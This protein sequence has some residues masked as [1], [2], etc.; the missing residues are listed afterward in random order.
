M[1]GP[2]AGSNKN[3]Y[4]ALDGLR[5][6]AALS[7]MIHHFISYRGATIFNNAAVA[8]DLFFILSGFVI[9][10]SYCTRL[11]SGMG[12]SE[13]MCRR[14][15]RLYPMFI[16]GIVIGTPVLYFVTIAGHSDFSM[17]DILDTVIH[18]GLF[19][20]YFANKW[21]QSL[22]GHEPVFGE[23]FPANPPAWSLFFEIF[24]SFAFVALAKMGRKTLKRIIIISYAS[25]VSG[26][27]LLTYV[28]YG[29]E[30]DFGQGWGT[31]NFIL[32]FPRVL[33]GFTFGVF[34]YRFANEGNWIKARNICKKYLRS[35]WLLYLAFLAVSAL[36]TTLDGLYPALVL[37]TVVP[38]LVFVGAGIDCNNVFDTT[39]SK[40][41]GWISY[42]IYC[43]HYPVGR[44]V[45]LLAAGGRYSSAEAVVLSIVIT[46]IATVIVTKLYEEPARAYLTRKFLVRLKPP[47]VPV[48]VIAARS[49]PGSSAGTGQPNALATDPSGLL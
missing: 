28:E 4:L 37:A 1:F 13:Y 43:L 2:S 15:I 18:N 6:I 9:T 26:I 47:S 22:G 8:V 14:F 39:A 27:L 10:H 5:G 3:R 25:F 20:P 17:R 34:L 49:E 35:P 12:T 11:Q 33:F 44:G 42:P 45:F 30:L 7:V 46:V 21:I 38:S 41:L 32:G 31:S 40:F 36:P 23:I 29:H 24:A 16:V 19:L 48:S